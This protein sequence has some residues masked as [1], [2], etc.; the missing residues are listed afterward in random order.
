MLR[1]NRLEKTQEGKRRPRLLRE[2]APEERDALK[3]ANDSET[4]LEVLRVKYIRVN[5]ARADE[6]S[7]TR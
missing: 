7:S 6:A 3:A 2:A 5:Y 4:Q 1:T